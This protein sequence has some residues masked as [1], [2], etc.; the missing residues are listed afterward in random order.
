MNTRLDGAAAS[1]TPGAPERSDQMN[2]RRREEVIHVKTVLSKAELS[3]WKV[4]ETRPIDQKALRSVF[5]I[6]E[7]HGWVGGTGTL[8]RTVDGGKTWL[9]VDIGVSKAAFVT[10][11]LFTNLA[12]GW[13]V[14]QEESSDPLTYHDNHF[15][16]LR[17]GDGGRTWTTQLDSED[18]VVN[19][20]RF[21]NE[22]EGWLVGIKYTGLKPLRGHD[23]IFHTVDLGK[24]W[25]DVSEPLNRM[26]NDMPIK[27]EF[28]DIMPEG[29]QT[30]SVLL[31]TGSVFKTDDAGLS[32]R[33]QNGI[34][35]DFTYV[36]SC[37]IG[38]TDNQRVWVGG[39]KDDRKSV[40]GMV[41]LKEGDSWKEYLLA[42]V[43]FS[44]IL[45]LSRDRILTCGSTTPNQQGYT[46]KRQA[47]VSY[48]SDGGATWS[49]VYRNPKAS[50]IS[51]LAVVD[52][53]HIWAVGDGG[54]I[55]RLTAT[56]VT[57]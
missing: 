54:L 27:V 19:Q 46:E 20:I 52:R 56:T 41:A 33:Q 57:H 18:S 22:R 23:F 1:K 26:L 31:P 37:Q 40:L 25:L 32:W 5:F 35:D 24:H 12:E 48:S 55:L 38:V 17:T 39:W 9:G 28:T 16:L 29:P 13:A 34:I 42:G 36:C 2:E 3:S 8:Y 45:F 15:W 47:V 7:M 49:F 53:D 11:F 10:K 43:S 30:A 44:D 6:D 50:K 14:A 4:D 51:A 21:A